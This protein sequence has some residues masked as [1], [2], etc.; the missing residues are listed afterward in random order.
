MVDIE[1]DDSR[2]TPAM[3][4][5]QEFERLLSEQA[6]F[7][8]ARQS[9]SMMAIASLAAAWMLRAS[10]SGNWVRVIFVTAFVVIAVFASLRSNIVSRLERRHTVRLRHFH[11]WR[12]DGRDSDGL[13]WTMRFY[14]KWLNDPPPQIFMAVA[15]ASAALLFDQIILVFGVE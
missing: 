7:A 14:S 11:G 6:M 8:H 15:V 10:H 2:L 12:P 13:E 9:H 3:T 1:G 4:R 5:R